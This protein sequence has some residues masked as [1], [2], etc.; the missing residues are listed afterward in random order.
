[1]LGIHDE[2]TKDETME[3]D[4]IHALKELHIAPMLDVSYRE[5]RY[6][7]RLL[8]KR[9]VLWT[10]MVVDET[11]FFSD[12]PAD[13]LSFDEE[14]EHPIVCQLGGNQPAWAAEAVK[15]MERFH[16]DEINLNMECPSTRVADKRGFGAALM[17]DVNLAIEMLESMKGNVTTVPISVKTRVGVDDQDDWTYLEGLI[18]RLSGVC[19][20]FF[21]HARKVYTTGLK[22][23]AQN[24]RIP[25]L[26][27]PR[28][29]RL[30]ERFPDCEFYING[31]IDSLCA[32][33]EICYGTNTTGACRLPIVSEGHC[34]PCD[35]CRAPFGS[36]TAPPMRAPTNLRGCM[37]GRAAI[38]NPALFGD[39]DRYFY[40]E[41][42][43]P[44]LS[45]RQVLSKYCAYLVDMYPRRCCDNDPRVTSKLPAPNVVHHRDACSKCC[46]VCILDSCSSTTAISDSFIC[47]N[48]SVDSPVEIKMSSRVVDR[49]LKPVLGI[50]YGLPGAKNWRRHL[51][52]LSRDAALRNCGPAH[53]LKVA[54]ARMSDAVL[55]QEFRTADLSRTEQT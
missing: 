30:C 47:F 14:C 26:N 27:Y 29:Y 38:D 13:H 8:T 40:G 33:R 35:I 2:P 36:C 39:V 25:P 51:D 17:K 34:I 20:R 3:K 1:M 43:N 23:A 54:M 28:V 46:Q 19:Q 7:I 6:F 55:D 18:A 31:G 16:Y 52:V 22:N 37:L 11:L 24:R 9:A 41:R 32:S 48:G 21:I 10:E 15:A 45:R 5:F 4:Q 44:C 12:N 50:F 49:C 42:T 53:I